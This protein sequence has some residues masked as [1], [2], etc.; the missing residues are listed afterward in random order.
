M[1]SAR[2][3]SMIVQVARLYYE[4]RLSQDQIA[5]Q[6]LTSRSN[7]SRILSVAHDRGIVEV[8]IHESDRRDHD[9]ENLLVRR[10]GLRAAHVAVIPK[11][12]TEYEGVG[13]L[14][15]QVFLANL[16]PAAKVAISWGR[17]LQAMV[18]ALDEVDR[19]DVKLIAIMGGMTDIPN[20]ISGETLLRSM[21]EKLNASFQVLHAPTIV[22][23]R[24]VRDALMREPSV[25]EVIEAA[26]QSD[27]A[28]VG[29]GSKESSSSNSILQAV[30]ISAATHPEFYKKFAG[31]LA[32][33]FITDEGKAV[34]SKLEDRTVGLDLKELKGLKRLI[35]VAAGEDKSPGIAAA[36]RGGLLAE[37]VTSSKCAMRLLNDMDK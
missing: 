23:N 9:L 16:K 5:K 19:R 32:G 3:K 14:A 22:Q 21:A 37:L 30:G 7:I 24:E 4:Q 18:N 34:D 26:K 8:R 15:A 13:Q 17:S 1:A 33:R 20:S 10:F 25:K 12:S 2:D 27:V 29:V 11:Y 28:F 36:L 35:G 6:L 31:D